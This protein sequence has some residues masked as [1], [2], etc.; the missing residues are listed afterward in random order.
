MNDKIKFILCNIFDFKPGNINDGQVSFLV[1]IINKL[2]LENL[3]IS[4]LLCEFYQ[5][6]KSQFAEKIYRYLE[7]C[8]LKELDKKID[9]N[10]ASL[11]EFIKD[12]EV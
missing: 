4:M 2:R 11:F 3:F 1:E 9:E 10:K 12:N 6:S 5:F 8:S 7:D